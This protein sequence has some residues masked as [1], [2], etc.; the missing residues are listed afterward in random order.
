MS[1]EAM[2]WDTQAAHWIGGQWLPAGP[3][4]ASTNPADGTLVGHAPAG[5]AVEARAAIDAARQAFETT[6]WRH[7]PRLRAQVLLDM[8][9][10]LAADAAPLALLLTLENGKVL[11]ESAGEVEGAASELRYYAG[12]ARS[13]AG[14]V[15][16][17]APG[18]RSLITH[19]AAGVVAIIVPWN[20]PLI[21]FVRSLAPALA[22][23]CTVV[24]KAAPQAALFMHRVAQRLAETE[25]LPPGTVNIVHEAG[26]EAAQAFV[27]APGVDVLSYTGSTAVGKAIM[28]AAAPQLKRL[29]LELGGKAPCVVCDDADLGL[30]VREIL[31]AGTI[32]SGQ[33]CTA[34]SRILVQRRLLGDFRD[35]M[36]AAMRDFRV[37]PGQLP[38]SRMG[39]VIDRANRDRILGLVEQLGARHRLVV[40]GG[41][42]ADLPAHGAFVS[43][44]L[45]EVDDPQCPAVQDEHFA[46]LMTLEAFDDDRGAVALANATRFGLGASVW[47]RDSARAQRIAREIRC[48]TVWINAH[49]KLFAEAEVGG[50][51]ESGFGRLHGAEGMHDFLEIKHVY[52][53]IG[54]L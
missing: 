52:Q 34:A 51:K 54:S 38:D 7:S 46:P 17:P 48:G 3:S 33:Q 25:G 21:L 10:R 2:R 18:V 44:T 13:A 23:G 49:N 53:E 39:A 6:P 43:P 29:S 12:M 16:E 4:F 26:S 32:L 8:A 35:A 50:Y 22:A 24:V 27:T 1:A 9:N 37:G 41:P 45:V 19:E 14:R 42:V 47:S 30:A 28:A 5:G 40:R 20:A 15:L 31:A 11:R 36:A